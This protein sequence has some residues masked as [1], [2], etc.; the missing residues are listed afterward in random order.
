MIPL[1]KPFM[2]ELPEILTI[3]NSGCLAYG[4]Y[5]HEFEERLSCFIN[6]E[7]VLVTN[8]FSTSILIALRCLGIEIGDEVLLS[9]MACLASTQ[10][11]LSAGVK[12]RWADIDPSFGTLSPDSVRKRITKNTKAIIHNHYC[13][14]L[15][16][17][18]EINEIGREYGIPIIDDCIEAFG[19]EYEG[20][21]LGNVETDAT[22][23]SFTAV[24]TPNT[25]DGGAV[26]FKNKSLYEKALLV[27]DC[28][29]DRTSFRDSYGEI[30]PRCDITMIGYSATMSD[31]NAYIG[32]QQMKHISEILKKQREN[33]QKWDTYLEENF[34]TIKPI[35][36]DTVLPNYWVYG[37]LSE[38]KM[39]TVLKFRELGFYASGVHLNNNCY[40]VFGEKIELPGVTEFYNRFVALPCGWW[41]KL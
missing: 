12:V 21:K 20:K 13:G 32:L 40:S 2:P 41:V 29:I 26:L 23:F 16:Y 24:R 7:N 36:R 34:K 14:Y 11:L 8:S 15:G 22:V 18:N 17:I 1:F 37:V 9:P 27:R 6:S 31:V 38:K 5:G 4:S 39:E 3:L 19:S 30:N 10:P 35:I 28:G 25:I 33:A